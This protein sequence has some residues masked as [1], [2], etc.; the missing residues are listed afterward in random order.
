MG[1]ESDAKKWLD[2]ARQ[3]VDEQKQVLADLKPE[4]GESD[5]HFAAKS[6]TRSARPRSSTPTPIPTRTA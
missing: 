1:R 4:P 5:E 2:E 6:S 3:R